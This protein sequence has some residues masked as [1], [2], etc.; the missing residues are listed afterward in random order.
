M[1][2]SEEMNPNIATFNRQNNFSMSDHGKVY[3]NDEKTSEFLYSSDRVQ[4][5]Q[6]TGSFQS[7]STFSGIDTSSNIISHPTSANGIIS[8]SYTHL[9]LPTNRE[10]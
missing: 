8:V 2:L 5:Q 4:F 7:S 9:T 10:V 1:S 3:R 6:C